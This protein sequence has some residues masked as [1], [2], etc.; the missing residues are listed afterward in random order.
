MFLQKVNDLGKITSQTAYINFSIPMGT[1]FSA[2][3]FGYETRARG[4]ASMKIFLVDLLLLKQSNRLFI[5][6]SKLYVLK[7]DV[8]CLICCD[9]V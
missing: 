6:S 1:H 5:A 7:L 9:F 4:Q 8:S 2:G 3:V